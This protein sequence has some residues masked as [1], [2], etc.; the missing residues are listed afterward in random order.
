MEIFY[1]NVAVKFFFQHGDGA[2]VQIR[3]CIVQSNSNQ[4]GPDDYYNCKNDQRVFD[5]RFYCCDWWSGD[6][7]WHTFSR[8]S[9]EK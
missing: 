5:P 6:F 7:E 3:I 9:D 4:D 8:I 2:S 1:F